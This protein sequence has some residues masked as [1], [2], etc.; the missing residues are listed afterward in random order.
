[1]NWNNRRLLELLKIDHPIIQAPMILQ[2][3]LAPLAAAV[4]NAGGLGSLGCAE[5]SLDELISN[6]ALVRS[7]TN[8][9]FNL[10]F[11][12]HEA[13]ELNEAIDESTIELV[14]PFYNE[15]GLSELPNSKQPSLAP[16]NDETLAALCELKPSVVSFHFGCPKPHVVEQLKSAGIAIL[17]TATTVR[18]SIILEAAGLDAIVAQG[19][20]AG[21]HRGSFESNYEETGVGTMAL[22]PQITD[23]VSIPVI[24]T[25]GIA[26]GRG[27]AAAMVLGA[28]GVQMGTA[29]LTCHETPITDQHRET[30]LNANDEDTSLSRAFSGRPC[31]GRSNRYSREMLKSRQRLP[32]FP[33]MYDFSGPLKKHGIENNNL[34]FQFLLYGQ[35][36]ALNKQLSAEG[37]IQALIEETKPL[38]PA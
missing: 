38:L 12:L 35:A 26:D 16:F 20:E 11:F 36:A 9:P 22:V 37:L 27:I 3:P 15:I 4:S 29:F 17:A 21:G 7:V 19:W 13:P 2:K 14:R 34:D 33:T 24:A 18:E 6:V 5:M 10:N 30:L 23:A 28:S 32:D 1:M 25:G 31:G 8:K